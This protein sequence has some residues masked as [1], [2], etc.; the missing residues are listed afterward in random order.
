MKGTLVRFTILVAPILVW[1]AFMDSGRS[2][3]RSMIISFPIRPAPSETFL[4]VRLSGSRTLGLMVIDPQGRRSGIDA[5][6][7]TESHEIPNSNAE[8]VSNHDSSGSDEDVVVAIKPT[9]STLYSLEIAGTQVGEFRLSISGVSPKLEGITEIL[10]GRVPADTSVHYQVDLTKIKL[11][12]FPDDSHPVGRVFDPA[13]DFVSPPEE[14]I[15]AP[16]DPAIFAAA[17]IITK[18]PCGY[19]CRALKDVP[20]E[21]LTRHDGEI[22]FLWK[23][24]KSPGCEVVFET[25]DTLLAGRVAPTFEAQEDTELY[26]LG[27]RFNDSADGPGTG[28]FGIENATIL[29]L[30]LHDQPASWGEETGKIEVDE[31]LK[32][33]VQ[34]KQK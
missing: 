7:Q 6:K 5:L 27:W 32:I 30:V 3:G 16:T 29:C 15:I 34:C 13:D 24:V 33:I 19:F 4:H 8:R 18:D 14:R 9:T 20:H 22:E 25:N 1:L 26:R 2:W 12:L 23:G 21:K 28:I 11:R 10:Y 17:A 31:N